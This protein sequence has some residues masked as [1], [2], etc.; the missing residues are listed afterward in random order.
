MLEIDT[1][2]QNPT[3]RRSTHAQQGRHNAIPVKGR[4]TLPRYADQEP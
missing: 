3:G 4:D 1:S 2:A